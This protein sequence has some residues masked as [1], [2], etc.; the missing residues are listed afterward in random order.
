MARKTKADLIAE[1]ERLRSKV[2]EVYAAYYDMH[3]LWDQNETR[4]ENNREAENLK[5]VIE[6]L[7]WRQGGLKEQIADLKKENAKLSKR[8]KVNG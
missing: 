6:Q 1:N 3:K 2:R 8:K 4:K 5:W 7:E